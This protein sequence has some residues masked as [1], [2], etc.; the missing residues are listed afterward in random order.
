MDACRVKIL[1]RQVD[2]PKISRVAWRESDPMPLAIIHASMPEPA[3]KRP[4]Y[5]EVL[6][7]VEIASKFLER[8]IHIGNLNLVSFGDL[9]PRWMDQLFAPFV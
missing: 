1:T 5:N 8:E 3:L 6:V 4:Q 9:H 2:I 7:D